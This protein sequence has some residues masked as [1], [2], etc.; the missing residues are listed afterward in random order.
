VV[1]S[2]V[3]EGTDEA[4]AA[5]RSL[6]FVPI[7]TDAERAFDAGMAVALAAA[8]PY[9]AA[10]ALRDYADANH[11]F[12]GGVGVVWTPAGPIDP[13]AWCT[14]G[15]SWAEDGCTEREQLLA[16][17]DEIERTARAAGKDKT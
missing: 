5:F 9:V 4:K 7:N 6:F 14:C 10:K 15:A 16:R 13:D 17:A 12:G 3:P 11:A 2:P 8:A 1:T